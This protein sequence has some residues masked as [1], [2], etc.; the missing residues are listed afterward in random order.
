[1]NA[2]LSVRLY[3]NQ[4]KSPGCVSKKKP[5]IWHLQD[6][7]T[8]VENKL[9]KEI[10]AIPKQF[11]KS[12]QSTSQAHCKNNNQTK[13]KRAASLLLPLLPL[14]VLVAIAVTW[15]RQAARN[16]KACVLTRVMAVLAAS[17]TSRMLARLLGMSVQHYMNYS[18]T[19]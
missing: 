19:H 10:N 17:T 3:H 15:A 14:V 1:M 6:V 5:A 18:V 2:N 4:M 16:Q 7:R 9:F 11:L 12:L 13:T 8:W